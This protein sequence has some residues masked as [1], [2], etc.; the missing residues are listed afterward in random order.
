MPN[1][2]TQ[3]NQATGPKTAEGKRVAARN[4]TSHGLFARDVVL[5]HLG[6]DPAGYKALLDALTGQ[7]QPHNLLEQ[8]YVEKIAAA[9]WRLRRLQRWQAQLFED[10]EITE[11]QALNKLDRVMRHETN[12]HRQIDTSVKM[13]AREL[14][15]LFQDRVRAELIRDMNGTEQECR[16]DPYMEEWITAETRR[17][18]AH[19][20]VPASVD[21]ATLDTAPNTDEKCQNEPPAVSSS[22]CS[23]GEAGRGYL[24]PPALGA[25]GSPSEILP[26]TGGGGAASRDGGGSSRHGG[27]YQKAGGEAGVEEI[28]LPNGERVRY[29]SAWDREKAGL[30]PIA[31]SA[32][33]TILPSKT[34]KSAKTKPMLRV[35]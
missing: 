28:V 31:P 12:L 18:V 3:A 27:G 17:R 10:P 15:K 5:P 11:D 23:E 19:E 33:T 16:E 2:D 13:L 4:A 29:T 25:G 21:P 7:L 14:P 30:P 1:T 22:P 20:P 34:M 24:S 35:G 26:L 6:E 9:S 32:C 8:H